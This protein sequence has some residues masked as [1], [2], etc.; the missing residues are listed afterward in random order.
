MSFQVKMAK[1]FAKI[2]K[3]D[4]KMALDLEQP[5]RKT[6]SLAMD[7]FTKKVRVKSW[8]TDGFSGMTMNGSYPKNIH[9]LMLPGGGYTLE[10]SKRYK[11]IAEYFALK[12]QAKVS[13]L[14]YPLS[15]EYT[16]LAAHQYL[17]N[18]YVRL[19]QEYPDDEFYL[20]GD[21]SGGGLALSFLQELRDKGNLPMPVRTAVVSP[22]L[23]IALENPKIKIVKKTDPFLPVE[24]LKEAGSRYRG[25]LEPEHP[26]VSPIYG[27]WN[28]LGKILIFSG[29]DEIMTPDCERLAEKAGK[30][31]ET[32]I[33]YKKGA[34]MF[35]DWI[36]IPC[37]ETD[38]TLD[39]IAAFFMEDA[40]VFK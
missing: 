13:I 1:F 12:E 25:N 9:I 37:K 21:F 31:K 3:A 15:P 18:S 29:A 32:Q 5:A 4:K 11:D 19:T 17:L 27:D 30:F 2:S 36:L 8:E 10:P 16:A 7:R 38:A 20:F 35:H 28:H 24:A 34:K 26:F 40:T 6:E 23:D 39:I 14:S 22:W 33:I